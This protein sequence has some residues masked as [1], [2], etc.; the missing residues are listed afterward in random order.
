M[1]PIQAQIIKLKDQLNQYNYSYYVLDAPDL[2]DAQYD[3]LFAQLQTLE[4]EHPEFIQNDSPT[5]RV[6]AKPDSKLKEIKHRFA[7]LSLSNGFSDDDILA[8]DRRNRER[9]EL[10]QGDITYV[11]EPKLDGLA[12]S[13][14]YEEGKFSYAVTRGDGQTGEDVS[15]NIKT[16]LS[17]PLTL[18]TD[19]P[20]RY[21]EARAEVI[22]SHAGFTRLNEQAQIEGKVYA[23]PRNAAAGS[24]RQLDP[25]I[26]AKRPLELFFYSLQLDGEADRG[27]H[28][29]NLQ[30]LKELGFRI[31]PHI[32][33]LN[34]IDA[35]LEY[36]QHIQRT[37][38]E[39][40]Y[41]I[42]G[43]VYKVDDM[44]QQQKLGWVSRAPRWALA[45][46]FPAQEETTRILSID[47]QVGRTGALTPVARLE[48]VH[49]GGVVVSNATLHNAQEIARLDV[50]V[51]DTVMVR[52]AGDVIPEIVSVVLS[53]RIANSESFEFPQQC[54]VCHSSLIDEGIIIKCSGSLLCDAQRL[55]SFKH[56]VSRKAMDIAGLGEKVI[57]QLLDE[58]LIETIAD[59]YTLTSD[60]LSELERFAKKSADNLV[61]SI[62]ASKEV[63]LNRFIYA[64]G[65]PLVGETTALTLA[66]HFGRLDKLFTIDVEAL[67]LIRDIG[68]LVAKSIQQFFSSD[69]NLQLI[70]DLLSHGIII[71]EPVINEDNAL[72]SGK[73]IVVTG[74]L[75]KYSRDEIKQKLLSFGAKVSSSVSAKT[76]F[77][78]VGDNP[79]SKADKAHSLGLVIYDETEFDEYIDSIKK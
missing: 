59:I 61:E 42:D 52:R 12:V 46:K 21:F 65:I 51:G 15:A 75:Q 58:K 53:Q 19:S 79:G 2:S 30:W 36:Y 14:V 76:D 64:L 40:G 6:G 24:L 11:A 33:R 39:L 26:T 73:T 20:P 16:I 4:N 48:P 71:I 50:R 60:Q 56:F 32:K 54:P 25:A 9:L 23:N 66:N 34:G 77:V 17:V 22:I 35:C 31:N 29:E 37:R 45:H 63:S 72:L 3:R 62:H 78:V 1:T 10:T 57:R 70:E 43:V 47:I 41:D 7:M 67:Q 44:A 74:T 49:V 38:Q 69:H 18:R 68:P 28:Y 8:F 55:E 5:Q 13:L 27:S